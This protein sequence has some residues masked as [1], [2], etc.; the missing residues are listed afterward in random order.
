MTT[1]LVALASYALG[2]FSAAYYLFR[3]FT[4]RD[5]RTRGSGN[6]GAKNIGRELGRFAFVV[7]FLVDFAKGTLA[8]WLARH[9]DIGAASVIIAAVAVVAGHIWPAQLHF[10]GGKG[11]ATGLGALAAFD[12]NFLLLSILLA[13][14]AALLFRNFTSAGLV[15]ILLTAIS[16]AI[17]Y[18]T[19]VETVGISI[20]AAIVLFAHRDNLRE[21]FANMPAGSGKAGDP[22]R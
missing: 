11:V 21:L 8:V 20:L 1:L 5:I 14:V 19:V 13:T 7:V 9:F 17:F 18:Q 16:A 10:R 12:Y 15:A 4:G 6:A 2:C 22:I 3:F